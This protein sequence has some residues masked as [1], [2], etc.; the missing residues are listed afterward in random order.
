MLSREF[1]SFLD[2]LALL[3]YKFYQHLGAT[4]KI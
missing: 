3:S 2:L 1:I 4:K